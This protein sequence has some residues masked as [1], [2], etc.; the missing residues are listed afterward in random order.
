[1]NFNGFGGFSV[2]FHEISRFFEM[3]YWCRGN[4]NELIR[5]MVLLHVSSWGQRVGMLVIGF[6]WMSESEKSCCY[7]IQ[8]PNRV[9]Q[10]QFD[11]MLNSTENTY[12]VVAIL[13]IYHSFK[14]MWLV[15]SNHY[16]MRFRAPIQ[17]VMLSVCRVWC[18]FYLKFD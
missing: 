3:G 10:I 9:D 8:H 4:S 5:S 14:M 15:Y 2:N 11:F 1:M 13:K 18:V 16:Q 7:A 12:V 6:R 17:F